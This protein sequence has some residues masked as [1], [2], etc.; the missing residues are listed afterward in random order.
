MKLRRYSLSIHIGSLF[1]ILTS[2]VGAVLILISYNHAQALLTETAKQ[3]SYEN[4]RKIETEYKQSIGPIL[5]TLDFLAFSTFVE[6]EHSPIDDKRWLASIALVFQKNTNLVALYFADDNG[7]FTI[8]R[9]LLDV[10][11]KRRFDAPPNAVLYAQQTQPNGQNDIFFL[12]EQFQQISHH[13]SLD[14]QFD[15]RV[16]PWFVSAQFDGKIRL[17]E[18]Y[19]FYFLKTHGVTLSRRSPDGHKVVGADFT[20]DSLSRQINGIGF[21]DHTKL[22]LFDQ[23]YNVLAQHNANIS[24]TDTPAQNRNKLN[25]SLFAPILNRTSSQVIYEAVNDGERDWSLTLTPVTLNPYVTLMLA[26]AMPHDDLLSNLLSMRN[27]QVKTAIILLIVCFLIVAVVASRLA[28]PLKTLVQLSDNITRFEFRKT[29]YPKSMIKEV[30]NLSQSLQLM[31]HTLHDLLKLL[32]N[33]ASNHDFNTLAK[34]ITQQSYQITRAETIILYMYSAEKESFTTLANHAII[35]FR[36]DI[37]E[38]LNETPWLKSQLQ[39]GELVHISKQDNVTKK[40]RDQL[41]NS[42][43]YLFPLLN[44][45]RQLIGILNLGYE[46]PITQE[47]TDKHAF[48][49]ELLGFAQI[50]KDNIDTLQQQKEMFYA[51]IELIASAI[52]TKS[53]HTKGHFQRVPTLVQWLTE[54]ATADTRYYPYF[55]MTDS[56]WEELNI[57]A[58]LHDCGKITTPEYIFDKT[59]KLETV[60]DRIHEIRM[61]FELLKLQAETDYWKGLTEGKDQTVLLAE[62]EETHRTLDEEFAFVAHCNTG[63]EPM[64]NEKIE[65]LHRI[66]QRS[67]KRTLDDQ[68][69]VSLLEKQRAGKAAALPVMEKLLD[70]KAAHCISWEEGNYPQDM[71]QE[72]FSLKPGP[73]LYNRGELHN[74]SVRHG[75]LTEEERFILNDHI[76]QTIMLLNKLPYPEHLKNIPDIAGSHHERMDGQGFPRGLK[77]EELSVQ[78]RV[79]AI[80]DVFE[81]LTSRDRPYKKVNTLSEVIQ[82]MTEMAVTGHLDPRIYLLFL[83]NELYLRYAQEFLEESQITPIDKNIH[84]KQVKQYLRTMTHEM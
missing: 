84:I 64:T 40:Y 76:V 38:L 79:M 6:K 72:D 71:W 52:D 28:K 63:S 24:V 39:K 45:H 2:I 15:P 43:I 50:A 10:Q 81:S 21:S 30:T 26:E 5:T 61:R 19:F 9:P 8:M 73:L 22:I 66:A 4:S 41:F 55:K 57:A 20:L 44:R 82:H 3:L 70:D 42:D 80:A 46:R 11:E 33:T 34:T 65:T 12:D 78:A 47:Q 37:N 68:S 48:L 77:A 54:A 32:R 7:D 74:L 59:T 67:W 14:N 75:T 25:N 23:Q 29:R 18:P 51:F 53:P 69:G 60:Y 31:E 16:R 35:P 13:Q 58:W 49:R 17:T 56:Q 1:L 27:Q 36:I 62:L 83:E